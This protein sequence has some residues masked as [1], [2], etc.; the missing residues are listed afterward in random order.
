MN[1][2]ILSV[3]SL[4]RPNT[5]QIR[6]QYHHPNTPFSLSQTNDIHHTTCFHT[7]NDNPS[8]TLFVA[9]QM[10]DRFYFTL[11]PP[12]DKS[13]V[14]VIEIGTYASRFGFAGDESIQVIQQ[15]NPLI[16]SF[17]CLQISCSTKNR[18]S[19]SLLRIAIPLKLSPLS[20]SPSRGGRK[21]MILSL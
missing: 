12:I 3:K 7:T 5:R 20:A 2:T 18:L 13:N 21:A 16:S 8:F 19:T 6:N 17:L 11:P 1:Q 10:P 14:I 9:I 4:S 15:T